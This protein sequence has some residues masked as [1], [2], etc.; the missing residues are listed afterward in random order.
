MEAT[1]ETG[2]TLDTYLA[3]CLEHL[4]R[5]PLGQISYLTVVLEREL[6]CS[7]NGL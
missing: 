3:Y 4:E 6:R 5:G 1:M 2:T 7:E